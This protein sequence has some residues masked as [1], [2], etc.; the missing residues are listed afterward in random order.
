MSAILRKGGKE[1]LI[2]PEFTFRQLTARFG[3]MITTNR[4]SGCSGTRLLYSMRSLARSMRLN[5]A[6]NLS[7]MQ[8]VPVSDTLMYRTEEISF[9][10]ALATS[11]KPDGRIRTKRYYYFL[12]KERTDNH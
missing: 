10:H 11:W 2:F 9:L 8:D 3:R 6:Q 5:L 12:L 1:K 4:S 7:V